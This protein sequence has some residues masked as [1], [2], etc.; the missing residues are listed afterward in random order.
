MFYNIT[1]SNPFKY[2]SIVLD[3]LAGWLAGWQ[4]LFNFNKSK[5]TKNL[6]E[7]NILKQSV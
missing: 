7:K 3:Y 4:H 5:R 2:V 6:I 1:L